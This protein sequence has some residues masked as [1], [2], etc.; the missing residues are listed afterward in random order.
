MFSRLVNC[1]EKKYTG[2]E[3]KA[4]YQLEC[5]LF[6][7]SN[8][9][10]AKAPCPRL[11]ECTHDNEGLEFTLAVKVPPL[12]SNIVFGSFNFERESL[13]IARCVTADLL[14]YK[15]G[16]SAKAGKI[17]CPTQ[18]WCLMITAAQSSDLVT[19]YTLRSCLEN[20]RTIT[21][22]DLI[23]CFKTIDS[24]RGKLKFS[25]CIKMI[26]TLLSNFPR[27][28][29]LDE[30]IHIFKNPISKNSAQEA[31]DVWSRA[32]IDNRSFPR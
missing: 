10:V 16:I 28:R 9:E 14:H 32:N 5:I 31:L 26:M 13:R 3:R 27:M 11:N 30:W 23:L 12:P 24:N 18:H 1:A 21:S 8:C 6:E 17:Y 25:W 22:T 4:N 15:Y 19:T 7:M 2:L 29:F 20:L